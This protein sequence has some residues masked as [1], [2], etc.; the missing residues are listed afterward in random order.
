MCIYIYTFCKFCISC[1]QIWSCCSWTS[2]P[3]IVSDC[4]PSIKRV[5]VFSEVP[6]GQTSLEVLL[7]SKTWNFCGIQKDNSAFVSFVAWCCRNHCMGP[8]GFVV[9]FFRCLLSICYIC[10]CQSDSL[11]QFGF[12]RPAAFCLYPYWQR[13][14]AETVTHLIRQR[15]QHSSPH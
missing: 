15:E 4:G 11:L 2:M 8:A 5:T 13:V 12:I 10:C 7:R 6:L 14:Q 3:G 9:P 1:M